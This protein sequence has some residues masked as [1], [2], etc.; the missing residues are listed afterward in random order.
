MLSGIGAADE[1]AEHGID[2]KVDLPNVGKKTFKTIFRSASKMNEKRT[3]LFVGVLRF[4]RLLAAMARAYVMGDIYPGIA[5]APIV[6]TGARYGGQGVSRTR[7]PTKGPS[8]FVRIRC[9]PKDGPEGFRP[10]DFA[11][12][13]MFG[14]LSAALIPDSIKTWAH[15]AVAATT[16]LA[17]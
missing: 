7:M 8:S 10:K 2:C 16:S 3:V 9:R 14:H 13:A 11:V 4:D 12:D 15:H 5:V 17:A 6:I 1:L